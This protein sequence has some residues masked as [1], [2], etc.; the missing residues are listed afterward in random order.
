MDS[1]HSKRVALPVTKFEFVISLSA[2]T[3]FIV[4]GSAECDAPKVQRAKTWHRSIEEP[5]R[6]SDILS[7]DLSY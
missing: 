7:S 3:M 2:F 1:L 5:M 6:A 4:A